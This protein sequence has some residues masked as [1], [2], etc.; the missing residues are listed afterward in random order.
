MKKNVFMLILYLFCS[1]SFAQEMKKYLNKELISKVGNICE[2]T[3]DDSPCSGSDI[4]LA[5]LFNK[6]KVFVS[7]KV[8]STCGKES[9]Y[10]IGTYNWKLLYSKE[11]SIEFDSQRIKG[12]YAEN[13]FLELR[14]KKLIGKITHLNGNVS[15][16]TFEEKK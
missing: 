13:L 5:F 9:I 8:I 16:C 3:N 14:N 1:I 12:T 7:E 10:K 4:F 15:E 11:I 2:E 6:E